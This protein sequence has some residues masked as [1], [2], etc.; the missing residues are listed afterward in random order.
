LR[1]EQ[2]FSSLEALIAQIASDV[3]QTRQLLSS[4]EI[5]G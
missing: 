2:R 3:E 4:E 5:K 1:G